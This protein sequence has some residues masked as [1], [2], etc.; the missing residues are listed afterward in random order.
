MD[1]TKAEKAQV[2]IYIPAAIWSVTSGKR[3]L[4]KSWR[5]SKR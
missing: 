1:I 3:R 2:V 4:K 5:K